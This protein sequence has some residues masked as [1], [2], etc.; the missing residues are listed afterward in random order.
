MQFQ[1]YIVFLG[2]RHRITT[3]LGYS[4]ILNVHVRISFLE[5]IIFITQSVDGSK[6]TIYRNGVSLGTSSALGVVSLRQTSNGYY[7]AHRWD[8]TDGVYG[9]Y[10]I[11]N[12]YNRALSSSEVTTNYNAVKSRFGL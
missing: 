5:Y 10:S 9:D 12:M 8:M 4:I 11:V 3:I 7:I 2:Y 6:L 1:V